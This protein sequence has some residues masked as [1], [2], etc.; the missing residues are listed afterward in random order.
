VACS[1][2]ESRDPNRPLSNEEGE[3]LVTSIRE[4]PPKPDDLTPAEKKY[5]M[6]RAGK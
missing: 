6:K 4:H 3:A 2:C 1:G 5:L